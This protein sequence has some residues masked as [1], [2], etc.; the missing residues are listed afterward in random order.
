VNDTNLR[1]IL[2]SSFN[3]VD[4][5]HQG[6]RQVQ[7]NHENLEIPKHYILHPATYTSARHHKIPE[8]PNP[9]PQTQDANSKPLHPKQQAIK[10]LNV[11]AMYT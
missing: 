6:F 8:A 1:R 10:K 9:R 4:D 11:H 7:S 2:A 3:S 5:I